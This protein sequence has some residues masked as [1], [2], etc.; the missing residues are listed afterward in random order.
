MYNN[1]DKCGI[2]KKIDGKFSFTNR[3]LY[4]KVASESKGLVAIPQKQTTAKVEENKVETTKPRGKK[5]SFK[6]ES[7]FPGGSSTG[8]NQM[9]PGGMQGQTIGTATPYVGVLDGIIGQDDW[10]TKRKIYNDI[11]TYDLAGA[12]VDLIANLPFS[13]YTLVGINNPEVIDTY[14]KT[15]D[16]LHLPSLLPCITTDYLVQGAFCGSL[17]WDDQNNR[18]SS[19]MPHDLLNCEVKNVSLFGVDPIIDLE[20]D[21]DMMELLNTADP[22]VERIKK[23]L[24][25]YIREAASGGKIELN[26]LSTLYIARRGKSTSNEGNSYFNRIITVHLLEKALIKGTIESAQR[27]QRAIT[28][29]AAGSEDWEPTAAELSELAN[30]F[31]SADI[32]PISGVVVTRNDVTV[33]DVKQGNDFWRWDEVFDFATNAKLRSLGVT[34]DV[35]TGGQS[36]NSLEASISLFMDNISSTRDYMTRQVFYD[37]IFP[38]IAHKNNF[39]VSKNKNQ[40][41]SSVDEGIDLSVYKGRI[42]RDRQ[43]NFVGA[44][45]FLGNSSSIFEIGDVTQYEMPTIQWDKQLKP[46]VDKDYMDMLKSLQDSGIP[47]SLRMMAAA[48]GEN[49]DELIEGMEDDNDLRLEIAEK[50]KDLIDEAVKAQAEKFLGIENIEEFLPNESEPQDTFA[51]LETFAKVNQGVTD[52]KKKFRNLENIDEIY[53]VREYDSNGRRRLLTAERKREL[54]NKVHQNFNIAMNEYA[55][56]NNY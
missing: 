35:L 23:I 26:P 1:L 39:L 49:I 14:M 45:S 56:K 10:Y 17:A 55:K 54:E 40:V 28:H 30:R 3:I 37:K 50:K 22:R 33:S 52:R 48:G 19:I 20:L 32:D 53:G 31:L 43:G 46:K 15:I 13:D 47:I 11:Y 29:I 18:F 5:K 7:A 8:F 16:N 41:L 36:F 24:P 21:P 34:E 44:G 25:D 27:R 51:K 38:I 12:V 2:S 4:P 42:K 6:I 9:G